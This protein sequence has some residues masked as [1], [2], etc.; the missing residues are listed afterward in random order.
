MVL[1]ERPVIFFTVKADVR[2]AGA[3]S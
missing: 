2:A 3:P 1:A